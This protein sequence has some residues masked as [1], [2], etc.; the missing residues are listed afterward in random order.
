MMQPAAETI[1]DLLACPSV[2]ALSSICYFYCSTDP[3]SSVSAAAFATY[4]ILVPYDKQCILIFA[5][6]A[7]MIWI[8]V[9]QACGQSSQDGRIR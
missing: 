4:P 3:L 7:V 8:W 5:T 6:S 2:V 9:F 1:L